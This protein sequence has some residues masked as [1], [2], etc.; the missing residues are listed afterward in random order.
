[1]SMELKCP[2]CFDCP[3]DD[4]WCS[5][6]SAFSIRC[7]VCQ[8]GIR[9]AAIYCP[10][11]LH[12]GHIDHMRQWFGQ[13]EQAY[14]PTGCGCEC[15]SHLKPSDQEIDTSD[16]DSDN[17]YSDHSGPS[18]LLRSSYSES[19]AVDSD[20]DS[21]ESSDEE[22]SPMHRSASTTHHHQRLFQK[23]WN[24]CYCDYVLRLYVD[25]VLLIK[26]LKTN[27]T[28]CYLLS[29][30]LQQVYNESTVYV[31]LGAIASPVPTAA[32]KVCL[33]L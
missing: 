4:N 3:L 31:V 28:I 15:S 7:G 21:S 25:V 12:G 19:S 14:C 23:R 24:R 10:V 2:T 17:S 30:Q 20:E 6:C 1:M 9:G 5:Q 27:C 32:K 18:R 29:L 11:C 33:S 26:Y 16:S 22:G 8:E 13:L